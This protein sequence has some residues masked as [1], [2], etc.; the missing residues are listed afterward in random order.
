MWN[1]NYHRSELFLLLSMLFLWLAPD[2]LLSS[3]PAE[4]TTTN[5]PLRVRK[6]LVLTVGQ[7]TGDLQGRDDKVIQ[8]GVDYLSRLG[9][10][11]LRIL[12]GTYTLENAIYLRPHI[13]LQGSGDRT[14]LKK[15]ASVVTAITR[16]SDWFEYGI[17]VDDANGFVPG[18]GIMI[19]LKTGPGAWQYDVLRATVM[20]VQGKTIFLDRQ[21]TE[22]FWYEKE[23]SVATL[24]PVLTAKE[25]VDDVVIKDLVLDGNRQENGPI[26]GNF[27]GGVFIQNC[28]RWHFEKVVSRNYHGDGFSFQ[29]CDDI[30]FTHC[31][32]LNNAGLGFHPGSGSQ[33]PVFQHC[34]AR[35]NDLGI[36]F[37]WSVSDGRA[38]DCDLSDNAGYGISIGHRDTDNLISRCRIERNGSVGILFRNEATVFRGGHRNRIEYCTIRDNGSQQ[39]GIGIDIQGATHDITVA[40]TRLENDSG[41]RQTVGIRIGP[42]AKNIILQD[43]TF[44]ACVTEVDDQR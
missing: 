21:T 40:Q 17:Q 43:N 16:D 37:C 7:A 34:I 18:G 5:R 1:R 20:D 38:I 32:A 8:A 30:Q 24:F 27:S 25:H 2:T 36:F 22:N 3:S 23:V 19:R 42:K 14:V 41:H 11:T 9:G 12:P 33:R 15:N 6:H 35:G 29:V 31:Q 13:T 39:G 26:N 28:N 10:G 4:P 44:K